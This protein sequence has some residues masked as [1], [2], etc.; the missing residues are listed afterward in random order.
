MRYLILLAAAGCSSQWLGVTISP[1]P[2]PPLAVGATRTYSVE[3]DFCEGDVVSGDDCG[4]N[5][6][7]HWNIAILSGSDSI[8]IGNIRT[9]V[10]GE[11]PSDSFDVTGVALGSAT[12]EI[13]GEQGSTV[14]ADVTV[15][16]M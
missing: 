16:P 14:T 6:P 7:D 9:G 1:Y 5:A 8:K 15:V 2:S 13:T 4:P 11:S 10:P 3:Q 12:L